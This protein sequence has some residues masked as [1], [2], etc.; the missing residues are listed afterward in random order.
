MLP[1][2]A[3]ASMWSHS[4]F[5]LLKPEV[6]PPNADPTAEA[7]FITMTKNQER[8]NRYCSRSAGQRSGSG[9][10]YSQLGWF[11]QPQH[12]TIYTGGGNFV[13]I[14]HQGYSG[15]D[16]F[17]YTVSDG[18]GGTVEVPVTITV[19]PG[20]SAPTLE[21]APNVQLTF[22]EGGSFA[23][24]APQPTIVDPDSPLLYGMVVELNNLTIGNEGQ[25]WLFLPTENFNE[26][27][28]LISSDP[29]RLE[30]FGTA[31]AEEYAHLL[32]QI[33][34][35]NSSALDAVVEGVRQIAVMVSDGTDW[36]NVVVADVNVVAVPTLVVASSGAN[37]DDGFVNFVFSLDKP[38]STPVEVSYETL[39]TNAVP[40]K[41]TNR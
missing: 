3:G 2:C 29:T 27:I 11:T 18:K 10:R 34:Y 40:V 36:S 12:G 6:L 33:R 41:I 9:R 16:T 35:F 24:F 7:D 38:S 23:T 30:F 13:Y 21:W 20:N 39:Q 32:E 22:S 17:T 15:Q 14:P 28:R 1:K 37:E 26:N 4:V 25:E 31:K 8:Y 5:S 19:E